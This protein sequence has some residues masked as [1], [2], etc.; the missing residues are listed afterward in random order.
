VLDGSKENL[1]KLIRDGNPVRIGWQLDFDNDNIPDFDHW[2]DAEFITILDNEV[3]TQIRNINAQVP[4]IDL[5]QIQIIPNN[6]MW[7]GVLGTNGILMNRFVYEDIKYEVDSLGQPI[8]TEDMKKEIAKRK[9]ESW[10]VST[11]WAVPK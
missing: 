11:F 7:T 2:M 9:P 3:F 1:I 5:P 8:I 10:K 6:L 4:N